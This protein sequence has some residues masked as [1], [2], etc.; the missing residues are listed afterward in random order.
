MRRILSFFLSLHWAVMFAALAVLSGVGRGHGF[1]LSLSALG[2]APPDDIGGFLCAP[3]TAAALACGFGVVAVLFLWT[4]VTLFLNDGDLPEETD[5]VARLA[6]GGA[7]LILTAVFIACAACPVRGLYPML[8]L[9]MTA[10]LASYVAVAAER[11]TARRRAAGAKG[12]D[13]VRV[14]ARTMALGAVHSSLLGQLTGR[15]GGAAEPR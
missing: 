12:N 1:P 5:D 13:D 11:G 7:V 15:S 2:L 3:A 10:L 4:L 9:E 8:A 14:A 6:F